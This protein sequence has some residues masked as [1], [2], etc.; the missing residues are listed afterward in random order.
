MGRNVI[1]YSSQESCMYL[2][3]AI[4]YYLCYSLQD[5]EI[6]KCTLM[7]HT[8]ISL[9]MVIDSLWHLSMM[10]IPHFWMA[11]HNLIWSQLRSHPHFHSIMNCGIIDLHIPTI[12]M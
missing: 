6:L 8:C 9:E 5:K 10:T 2:C 7:Q 1:L 4:I 12:M 3:F 11:T